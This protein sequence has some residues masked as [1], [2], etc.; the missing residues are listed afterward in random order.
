[1]LARKRSR[2][3]LVVEPARQEEEQARQEFARARQQAQ[4]VEEAL[5]RLV[6]AMA[7][8]DDWARGVFR[9]GGAA[10][11]GSYR[12]CAADLREALLAK[13][14]ELAQAQEELHTRRGELALRM[15]R[16]K[17]LEQ[18]LRRREVQAAL[19]ASRKAARELDQDHAARL[20]WR[21]TH[22][23]GAAEQQS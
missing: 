9:A 17:G 22:S 16:R 12:Q 19:D 21:Q 15:K 11:V 14:T 23:V 6:A 7:G 1:M 8:Q 2:L 4:V 5:A 3:Q 20:A 13:R 10:N 18:A